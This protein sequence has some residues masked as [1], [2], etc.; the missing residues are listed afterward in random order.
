[1]IRLT[2]LSAL[3]AL[4][5][6]LPAAAGSE[7]RPERIRWSE[8]H[9]EAKKLGFSIEAELQLKRLDA[10]GLR[11]ELVE[12]RPG[13]WFEAPTAGGW[14]LDLATAGLGKRS[15][16]ALLVDREGRSLQR[17]Q[18]ETGRRLKD[19]R[20]RTHRF[21]DGAV[22]VRTL[23]PTDSER[24]APADR[25]SQRDDWVPELPAGVHPTQSTGL[26]Y[27]LAAA[28]LDRPGDHLSTHIFAK[29][30]VSQVDLTVEA[31]E[32]IDVEF[33]EVAGA[34]TRRREERMPALRIRLDGQMLDADE[35][36]SDFRFLGLK[37][38]VHVYVDPVTRAPLLITGK[39]GWV[40]RAKVKLRRL[41][42]GAS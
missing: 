27:T 32:S 30:A 8:L 3:F 33:D 26:F 14:R 38:T 9:Y 34:T 5:Y 41:V 25:W 23:R 2:P 28:D 19:H 40:G 11:R 18:I 13:A 12:P 36:D 37:G 1:M 39:I 22:H 24:D 21:G 4:L 15:E 42:L 31:L 29:H 10:V 20:N 35:S 16:L 17:V 6:V 7:Y